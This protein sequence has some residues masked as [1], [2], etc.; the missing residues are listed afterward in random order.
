MSFSKNF[1]AFAHIQV[2]LDEA[3]Q[4]GGIRYSLRS[5]KAA[6]RWKAQAYHFRKLFQEEQ[7][8]AMKTSV[9]VP[10]PYDTIDIVLEGAVCIIRMSKDPINLGDLRTLDNLPIT[11]LTK[12]Y[13]EPPI[14]EYDTFIEIAEGVRQKLLGDQDD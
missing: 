9:T 11:E 2:V 5:D 6:W 8:R 1:R 3:V 12:R 13:E 7:T 14:P 10:T 4:R